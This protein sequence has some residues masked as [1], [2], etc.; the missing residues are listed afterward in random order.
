MLM[1][2]ILPSTTG[3]SGGT[4]F[5]IF[6]GLKLTLTVPLLTATLPNF[7]SLLTRNCV[8]LTLATIVLVF[9]T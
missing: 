2:V 1:I 7:S 4:I 9:I 6:S 5:L 8:P 3:I